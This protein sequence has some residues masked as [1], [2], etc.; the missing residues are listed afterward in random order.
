MPANLVEG[1]DAEDVATYVASVAGV[2]GIKPPPLRRPGGQI[3]TEKLRQ[4]PRARRR[5]SSGSVGP[6]LDDALKG[7]DEAMI[8]ESIVD[9]TP[10]S[11]RASSA[12]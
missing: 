1:Q 12:A 7:K 8:E 9:P 4:L 6:N 5:G 10:R 11:P 2:P 3:F